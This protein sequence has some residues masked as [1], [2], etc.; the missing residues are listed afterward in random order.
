MVTSNCSF[1]FQSFPIFSLS[2]S[3]IPF[4]ILESDEVHPSREKDQLYGRFATIILERVGGAEGEGEGGR[5]VS[6]V[7]QLEVVSLD[8]GGRPGVVAVHGIDLSDGCLDIDVTRGEGPGRRVARRLPTPLAREISFLPTSTML[9]LAILP[10]TR[11][12]IYIYIYQKLV[13][14]KNCTL[15]LSVLFL[16]YFFIM[17]I[18]IYIHFA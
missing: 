10:S 2:L 17:Y 12:D 7:R 1:L 11:K 4:R 18:Y 8:D 9:R 5:Q 15:S 14:C 13:N 6:R 3:H 16:L